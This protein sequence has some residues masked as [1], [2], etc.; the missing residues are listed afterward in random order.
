VKMRLVQLATDLKAQ[1]RRVV[2][3]RNVPR[4]QWQ[5]NRLEEQSEHVATF[6]PTI[7]PGLLQTADYMR[8]VFST[9]LAGAEL[10]DA[11]AA[12]LDRQRR[13]TDPARRFTQ[14]ITEGALLWCLGSHEVMAEQMDRIIEVSLLPNVQLGVI[15]GMTPAQVLPLHGFDVYDERAAIVA[16]IAATALMTDPQDVE[17]H[18]KMLEQLSEVA[19][20]GD[21]ARAVLV[22]LRDGYQASS[23]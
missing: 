11:V 20:Y 22:R 1:N 17:A 2:G 14:I 5:I 8:A 18:T 12:R 9:G 19:V 15:P 6:Q 7:V 3:H 16:T 23:R 13:L 10:E 4:F 21:Q